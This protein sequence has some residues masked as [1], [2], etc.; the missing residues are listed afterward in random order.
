[1]TRF[2]FRARK[3]PIKK[4][5]LHCSSQYVNSDGSKWVDIFNFLRN[6]GLSYHFVVLPSGE[7]F[8]L[9]DEKQQFAFHVR[10]HNSSSVGV[11]ALMEG[12]NTYG[13]FITRCKTERWMKEIQ[14]ESTKGLIKNLLHEYPDADFNFHSTLDPERKVDP[15]FM[16][17]EEEFIN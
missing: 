10:G 3:N 5:I 16:Y 13:E 17:K 8:K 4:I 12:A 9:L 11:C 7:I 15:G 1:M 2:P 14:Y 6:Q